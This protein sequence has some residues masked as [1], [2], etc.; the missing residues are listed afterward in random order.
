MNDSA[1]TKP[2]LIT[3]T[4]TGWCDPETG[5]C[6]LADAPAGTATS[7][8]SPPGTMRAPSKLIVRGRV[9]PTEDES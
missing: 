4:P 2:Q 8:A 6:Q 1:D 5:A 7:A 3:S 9:V